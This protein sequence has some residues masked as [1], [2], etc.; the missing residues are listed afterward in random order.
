VAKRDKEE[1]VE[2]KD[3]EPDNLEL[4]K[5]LIKSFNKEGKDKIAWC[6]ATDEDNPTDVK[7]F[8]STGSTL[9]DFL[10]RNKK[11]GG[12]PVGK[13]TEIVGEEASGKSLVCAAL[14]AEVQRRGGVA[15]YIDTESSA[16]PEFMARLGVNL[17]ELVYLQPATVE[18]VGDV[19]EKVVIKV[20]TGTPNR[21]VLIIW[22][23]VAGTP[24]Q[25]E[26]EGTYDIN[27]NVQLEKSKALSLM[28][29]KLNMVWGK[30]RIALVF[31]NQLKTKIGVMYGDPMTTPGGKA[32]PYHASVRIRLT[33]SNQL[34]EGAPRD[35]GRPALA[36]GDENVVDG[37]TFGIFTR[38]KV[39]KSRLGP[40]L[41]SCEFDILFSSGIDDIE[42]WRDYLHAAKELE[43]DDGW[44]FMP[45]YPSGK[46]EEKGAHKGK[47]RGIKFREGHWKRIVSGDPK[48]KDHVLALLEKHLVVKYGEA[49]KDMALDPESLMDSESVGDMVMNPQAPSVLS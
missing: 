42:S 32:I 1:K 3:R 47:D 11:G 29:R 40:P 25:V 34:K 7:E 44:F 8:I 4:S 24:C 12:V 30:E 27:M 21:L 19:I 9:L 13:L 6:L 35:K 15:V 41:R 14:I 2:K 22:D 46:L 49:P 36:S 33:R 43:K 37:Q 18:E 5:D 16:N 23:S 45:S 10:I 20:R 17:K 39:I 31:T 38:A 28:M 48:L 26:L